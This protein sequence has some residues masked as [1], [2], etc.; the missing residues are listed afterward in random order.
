MN[1]DEKLQLNKYDIDMLLKILD[2]MLFKINDIN[3]LQ[4]ASSIQTLLKSKL[5][6]VDFI[7]ISLEFDKFIKIIRFY[8]IRWFSIKA[9]EY[10]YKYKYES[11]KLL[12]KLQN[13]LKRHSIKIIQRWYKKIYYNPNSNSKGFLLAQQQFNKNL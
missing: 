13:L 5:N 4:N 1:S 12:Y 11:H 10:E 7:F 8:N 3:E 6:K 9:K 2:D